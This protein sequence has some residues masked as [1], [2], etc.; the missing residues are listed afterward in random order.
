MGLGGKGEPCKW[1]ESGGEL[2]PKAV[3][4]GT[5]PVTPQTA[6]GGSVGTKPMPF[7]SVHANNFFFNGARLFW[8]DDG[9]GGRELR[10]NDG[11][12]EYAVALSKDESLVPKLA[13]LTNGEVYETMWLRTNPQYAQEKLADERIVQQLESSTVTAMTARLDFEQMTITTSDG[14][15]YGAMYSSGKEAVTPLVPG[16]AVADTKLTQLSSAPKPLAYEDASGNWHVRAKYNGIDLNRYGQLGANLG[17][18]WAQFA[19][20]GHD[21]WFTVAEEDWTPAPPYD[22][23]KLDSENH[24]SLATVGGTAVSAQYFKRRLPEGTTRTTD[25]WLNNVK[26]DDDSYEMVARSSLTES[27]WHFTVTEGW[28]LPVGTVDPTKD[29]KREV[30]TPAAGS[31]QQSLTILEN[32]TPV[33]YGSGTYGRPKAPPWRMVLPSGET[34]PVDFMSNLTLDSDGY[35]TVDMS[36]MP[37]PAGTSIRKIVVGDDFSAWLLSDGTLWTCGANTRGQLGAGTAID[38]DFLQTFPVQVNI[39]PVYDISAAGQSLAVLLADGTLGVCG[40]NDFGQLDTGGKSDQRDIV[41]IATDVETMEMYRANLLYRKGG[42]IYAT[43]YNG[44]GRFD[45]LPADLT[46]GG[47]D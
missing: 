14:K 45:G 32:T 26:I 34:E 29:I 10:L 27:D 35:W 40:A 28:A 47:A 2:K 19:A 4:G 25:L 44:D 22:C 21:S 5:P 36:Y 37:F 13:Y 43:G 12:N 24:Y 23:W 20:L 39:G 42:A 9:N 31:Y 41:E 6:G 30:L 8:K 16:N 3:N 15:V 33:L 17:L 46:K 1:E 38:E 7:G 18:P 11:E